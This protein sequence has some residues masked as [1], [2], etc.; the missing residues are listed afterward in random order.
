MYNS[1][2]GGGG[3]YYGPGSAYHTYTVRTNTA[4]HDAQLGGYHTSGNTAAMLNPNYFIVAGAVTVTDGM[5]TQNGNLYNFNG[6]KDF[7]YASNR[8]W[9]HA[10][11]TNAIIN[12]KQGASINMAN[13]LLCTAYRYPNANNQYVVI[14]NGT[15][16]IVQVSNLYDPGWIPDSRINWYE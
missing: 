9:N 7:T 1:G 14:E 6:S 8:G 12:G 2:G 5:V 10:K 11:I 13:N 15:R 16:C 3:G 4:T